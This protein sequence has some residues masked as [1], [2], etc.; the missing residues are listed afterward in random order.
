MVI[1]KDC[2]TWEKDILQHNNMTELPIKNINMTDLGEVIEKF[3]AL[4]TSSKTAHE[5]NEYSF[6]SFLRKFKQ[7]LAKSFSTQ[8]GWPIFKVTF[9]I[10]LSCFT[11][12][13][14]SSHSTRFKWF[15][16]WYI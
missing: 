15:L 4:D 12:K 2:F 9:K 14:H 5:Y 3:W 8:E 7:I 16:L 1:L 10:Y 6:T 13:F 11:L